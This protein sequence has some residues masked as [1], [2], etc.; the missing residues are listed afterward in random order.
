MVNLTP[1]RD[2]DLGDRQRQQWQPVTKC[3]CMSR[4]GSQFQEGFAIRRHPIS[5]KHTLGTIKG[6][7]RTLHEGGGL[8]SASRPER[9]TNFL[10]FRKS[11]LPNNDDHGQEDML[12]TQRH[13]LQLSL[14]AQSNFIMA[15]AVA[16]AR[17]KSEERKEN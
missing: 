2:F 4:L 8:T 5:E 11:V 7:I 10:T 16:R 12:C 6:A 9:D 1:V 3:H 13:G 15:A 17:M 14:P